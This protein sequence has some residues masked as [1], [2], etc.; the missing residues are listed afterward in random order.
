ME[1]LEEYQISFCLNYGRDNKEMEYKIKKK[2][3]E[4]ILISLKSIGISI[5][6]GIFYCLDELKFMGL[7]VDYD[8]NNIDIRYKGKCIFKLSKSYEYDK[9]YTNI[10]FKAKKSF[11]NEKENS[12]M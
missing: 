11:L 3:K 4:Y 5:D 6:I 10:E 12:S 9:V 7:D 8:E 2:I 1:S